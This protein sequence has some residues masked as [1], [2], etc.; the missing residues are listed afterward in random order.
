[1]KHHRFS[2][3]SYTRMHGIDPSLIKVAQRALELSP[4]DFGI[5]EYGGLRTAAEQNE[6]YRKGLSQRDGYERKSYHQSGSALD[7]FAFVDGKASWEEAHLT[8][9]AAAMLQA[10]SEFGVRMRWG[11]HWLDFRDM[12]HF[13]IY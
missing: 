3:T 1:M 2:T 9:V 6:L 5:P 10:A 4:I 8:T 7:V 13:E 11:G 12:P